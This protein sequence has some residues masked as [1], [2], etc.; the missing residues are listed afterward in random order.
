MS[1]KKMVEGFLSGSAKLMDWTSIFILAFITVQLGIVV[2][3]RYVF[4]TN[5]RWFEQSSTI[6]F[7]YLVFIPAGLLSRSNQHLNVEV[8]L[9]Y[10]QKRE[11]RKALW[12]LHLLLRLTEALFCALFLYLAWEYTVHLI[13]VNATF[14]FEFFGGR[15]PQWTTSVALILGF[16]FML[17]HTVEALI[18][19][20]MKKKI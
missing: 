2:I 15:V 13:E 4:F 20:L 19:S 1:M 6:L 5:V 17:V 16:F 8:L 10:L 9:E 18:T 12:I 3:L 11:K 7:F 14:D